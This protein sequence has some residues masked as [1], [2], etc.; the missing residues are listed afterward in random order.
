MSD[1]RVAAVVAGLVVIL[2]ITTGLGWLVLAPGIVIVMATWLNARD[3]NA[4]GA[5][6]WDLPST[7]PKVAETPAP[8]IDLDDE[9][10]DLLRSARDLAIRRLEHDGR[11]EPFVMFEDADGE[12]RVRKVSV[13]SGADALARGRTVARQVDTSAPRVVLVVP[14]LLELA[15]KARPAILFEAGEHR[16]EART[17]AFAQLY[18]P[19]RLIFRAG[20]DGPAM[21]I[22]E[23]LH[24][25]RFAPPAASHVHVGSD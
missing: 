15:G 16:F 14:G 17:M 18:R 24:S 12:F 20:A 4:Y 9:L 1:W 22:G 21:Y 10:A 13:D 19:K 6:P 8:S 11:V 2:A 23:A 3:W 5:D 7:A 25:L